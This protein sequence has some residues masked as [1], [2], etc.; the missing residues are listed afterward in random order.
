VW[1]APMDSTELRL[2]YYFGASALKMITSL[3]LS[4]KGAHKQLYRRRIS[5]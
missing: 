3:G 2:A 5:K 1:M 4:E